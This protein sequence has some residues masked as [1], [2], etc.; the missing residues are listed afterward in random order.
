MGEMMKAGDVKWAQK[1][2]GERMVRT[3]KAGDN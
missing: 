2:T 1:Q 3:T